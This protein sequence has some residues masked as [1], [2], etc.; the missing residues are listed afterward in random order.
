MTANLNL[1]LLRIAK[2]IH[3]LQGIQKF[4]ASE[5]YYLYL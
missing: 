4:E 2:L 1:W 3:L 5:K